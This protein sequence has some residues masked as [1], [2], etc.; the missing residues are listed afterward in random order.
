MGDEVSPF[1]KLVKLT[2]VF[3]EEEFQ[4]QRL[5]IKA[6]FSSISLNLFNKLISPLIGS[7]IKGFKLFSEG[8]RSIFWV[9][10]V[11]KSLLVKLSEY[12]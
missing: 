4:P 7:E 1:S 10:I 8:V 6:L 12:S 11:P 9:Q 5:A 3:S 2:T